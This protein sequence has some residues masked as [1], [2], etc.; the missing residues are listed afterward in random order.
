MDKMNL[1]QSMIT[2]LNSFVYLIIINDIEG[3]CATEYNYCIGDDRYDY[4]L[5]YR[6][7]L[8]GTKGFKEAKRDV[9]FFH[10]NNECGFNFSTTTIT[11]PPAES[12]QSVL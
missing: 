12:F 9:R 8:Y 4:S 2:V 5:N 11:C 3:A 6:S 7:C 1:Y 10:L